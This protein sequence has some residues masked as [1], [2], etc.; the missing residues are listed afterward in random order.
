MNWQ[1][2]LKNGGLRLALTLR[3]SK[4]G[5]N[6]AFLNSLSFANWRSV[7]RRSWTAGDDVRLTAR[8]KMKDLAGDNFGHWWSIYMATPSWDSLEDLALKKLQETAKIFYDYWRIYT[9]LKLPWA[10]GFALTGI[11]NLSQ[12][13]GA[14]CIIYIEHS[15]LPDIQEIALCK[16]L[17]AKGTFEEWVDVRK[18]AWQGGSLYAIALYKIADLAETASHWQYVFDNSSGELEQLAYQKIR[19]LSQTQQAS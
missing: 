1:N 17:A 16:L 15:A 2:W 4:L 9:F 3:F 14:W 18:H 10:K 6:E 11:R 12:S 5:K 13:I 8:Y 19:E 7:C